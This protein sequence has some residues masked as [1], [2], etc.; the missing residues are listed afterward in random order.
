MAKSTLTWNANT[1]PDLAGYKVYRGLGAAGPTLLTAV[2]KVVTYEDAGVP[3]VNQTV[4][5]Q[6][7]AFDSKGN[8][9]AKCAPIS[10]TID[11]SPPATPTGFAVSVTVTVTPP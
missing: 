11:V 9:S 3:D 2:G 6:L 7:S 10:I 5:Y 1:E 4:T 8:E